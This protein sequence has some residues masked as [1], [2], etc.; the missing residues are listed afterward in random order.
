MEKDKRT[1]QQRARHASRKGKRVEKEVLEAFRECGIECRLTQHSGSTRDKTEKGDMILNLP[2][3]PMRVEV[4]ARATATGF[5]GILRWLG[6][7]DILVVKQDRKTPFVVLSEDAFMKLVT[8]LLSLTKSLDD[9][10]YPCHMEVREVNE[11]REP[12]ASKG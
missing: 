6:K 3:G 9:I 2:A 11:D 5:T 1:P 10:G 4:K 7:N 8:K 12:I